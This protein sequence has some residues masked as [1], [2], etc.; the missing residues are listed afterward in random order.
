VDRPPLR[1]NARMLAAAAGASLAAAL[2]TLAIAGCGGSS[3]PAVA[4]GN[5]QTATTTVVGGTTTTGTTTVPAGPEDVALQQ[6]APLA[7]ASTTLPGTMIDDGIEC[8]SLEQLAYQTHVMLTVYV[9]GAPRSLPGAIGM[10]DPSTNPG[11]YGDLYSAHECYY[12][13]HTDAAD[14]V[15][16]I[17]SPTPRTYTLGNFFDVWGQLLNRNQVAGSVGNVTAIVNGHR[18]SGSPRRIPLR[19]HTVIELAVGK[20]VPPFAGFDW[21][22]TDL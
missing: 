4:A 6:G 21:S 10:L 5:T 7:P 11:Q 17:D 18:W 22:T 12:W 3:T 13:L 8:E 14:G 9:D 1:V 2:A 16:Q 19:S 15:I 20:P